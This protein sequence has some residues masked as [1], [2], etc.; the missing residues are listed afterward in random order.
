MIKNNF[1]IT[2]EDKSHILNLTRLPNYKTPIRLSEDNG[3]GQL[4]ITWNSEKSKSDAEEKNKLESLYDIKKKGKMVSIDFN[5][6]QM[7]KSH[8]IMVKD[9]INK[10][11]RSDAFGYFLRGLET[12]IKNLNKSEYSTYVQELTKAAN[13]ISFD[14]KA[15]TNYPIEDWDS[16][17]YP[18]DTENYTWE[19]VPGYFGDIL[20][21]TPKRKG[22]Y[23]S[24]GKTQGDT[25]IIDSGIKQELTPQFCNTLLMDYFNDAKR[26]SWNDPELKEKKFKIALCYNTSGEEIAKKTLFGKTK[27]KVSGSPYKSLT[28]KDS[29]KLKLFTDLPDTDKYKIHI[30]D[31]NKNLQ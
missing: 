9:K 31:I 17:T 7:I 4:V 6:P 2:E 23:T 24:P 19:D 16:F 13:A 22:Y 25:S 10:Y 1:I 27:F 26:K 8:F 29:E 3:G 21:Y 30:N 28:R 20:M 18:P 5:D 15:D 12:A 11:Y 14:L